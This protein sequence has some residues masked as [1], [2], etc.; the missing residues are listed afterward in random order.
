MT[1]GPPLAISYDD[2]LAAHERIQD[3]IHRTPVVTSRLLDAIAGRRLFFKCENLQRGGAFKIR[4]ATSKMRSLT[5]E[6]RR[7]GVAAFSSGNHAQAV[8]IAAGELGIDAKIVMPIDAPRAKVEATRAYGATIVTYD[9]QRDDREEL[10]RRLAEEEGRVLVAPYDDPLVMAGQGTAALELLEDVPDL[11]AVVAPVGGG[12]LLAGTATAA[13]GGA[14]P[15]PAFG[16]E[17]AQ[18]DDTAR[19]LEAGERIRIPPPDTIA[20]GGRAEIPGALTFPI[21]QVRAAGVVL[22]PEEAILRAVVLLLTRAKILVEPTGALAAAA[23][24]EG[25]L[26]PE[27]ERVGVILSGG[28]IDP[29]TLARILEG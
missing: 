23:A 3:F 1:S 11:D 21:L 9:R 14:R 16:A 7:R 5:P 27:F 29:A 28:N 26:P 2:V 19:S 12:G 18:A 6:E 22:V 8:A 13:M 20:D 15:V 10:G 17:P 25:L 24:L 4:G